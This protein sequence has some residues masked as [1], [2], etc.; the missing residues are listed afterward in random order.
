MHTKPIPTAEVARILGITVP[1]V[2]RMVAA[3]RLI[4]VMEAE[5]RTGARFF[6]PADVTREAEARRSALLA[7]MPQ[8]VT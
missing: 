3:G 5:G 8:G 2:H 1:T 7:R 4:P 6:D